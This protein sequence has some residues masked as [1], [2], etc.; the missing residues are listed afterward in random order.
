MLK[1]A[2]KG[3]RFAGDALKWLFKDMGK[4]EIAMRIAPDLMFGGL[5]A[6]MTPGDI[7]DK[8]IAGTGS[9]LG[10]SL[11]GVALGKLGGPGALG[12]VLDMAGSIGGDMIGREGASLILRGKDKLSGGQGLTPYEKM[13][14][15][16]QLELLQA[17]K[18]QALAE[19]GL[20]PG[21]YQE[22]LTDPSTGMGVS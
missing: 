2:V 5:E 15:Q 1:A 11:G 13:S 22:F 14:E 18:T 12:T 10:G 17:G 4:A 21:N 8:L 6:A 9:A 16:Q 20:L 3:G 7:G 19:L